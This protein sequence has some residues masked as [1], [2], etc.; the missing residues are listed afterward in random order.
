MRLFLSFTAPAAAV[1]PPIFL[2]MWLS[3]SVDNE[4]WLVKLVRFLTDSVSL[5]ALF[6]ALVLDVNSI[7]IRLAN[8]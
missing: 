1:P 2:E 5:L 6:C 8:I 7:I 3:S 4:F